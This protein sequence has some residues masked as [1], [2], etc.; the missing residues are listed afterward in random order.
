M[1]ENMT[2]FLILLTHCVDEG[3]VE[4]SCKQWG[5]DVSKELFQ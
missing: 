1:V 4:F 2:A 3:C 5:R